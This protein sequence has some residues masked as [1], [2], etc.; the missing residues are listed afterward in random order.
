MRGKPCSLGEVTKRCIATSRATLIIK[1][2][3]YTALDIGELLF[4]V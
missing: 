3:A 4:G 1:L 2:S